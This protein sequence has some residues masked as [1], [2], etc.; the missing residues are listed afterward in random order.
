MFADGVWS[1]PD[2]QDPV[3][4]AMDVEI[5]ALDP[6]SFAAAAQTFVNTFGVYAAAAPLW[7]KLPGMAPLGI[8]A[9]PN[10]RVVPIDLSWGQL[11]TASVQW[12]CP[13]AVWQSVPR[14]TLLQSSASQLAGL[15]F[16]L[17]ATAVGVASLPGALDFGMTSAG[18]NA[19][20]ISNAGNTAAWPVVTVTG[21]CP[22]GFT[23]A[24][25]GH[26]VTYGTDVPPGMQIA[27][28][29]STGTATL[30]PGNV[31][32]TTQLTADDF[33]SVLGTSN[34]VFNAQAGTALVTIADMQR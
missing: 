15:A 25:D 21:P 20:Q 14:Q 30:L 23:L 34:V 1:G 29:Y 4:P 13:D 32:R 7:F 17:F 6:V 9:K 28:D 22:G 11:S 31:D 18:S 8:G 24:L 27:V 19:A 2:F 10:K 33:T 3:T 12:R 26:A 16:P 5:S